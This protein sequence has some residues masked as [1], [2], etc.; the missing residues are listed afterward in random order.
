MATALNYNK[1]NFFELK[2]DI[3][4]Y[5]KQNYPDVFLNLEDNSVGS[6]F[7][8]ILAGTAEANYFNLDRVFQETQLE[9]AQLKKSLF[10]IAKNLGVKLPNKKPSVTLIDIEAIVPA[11][12]D[13]FNETYLPIV[14]AGTQFT[15][16][17]VTFELLGDCDFSTENSIE[18]LPE[19]RT[20]VPIEN[21]Y[22]EIVSYR[23]TKQEVVYNGAT[24]I[25]RR[26][27]TVDESVPFYQIILPEDDIIDIT[28]IVVLQGNITTVPTSDD[29]NNQDL[30]FF[31]VDYL[32]ETEVFLESSPV[33]SENGVRKGEWKK[34]KKKFIKEFNED[35][36]CRITFGGGD[37]NIDVFANSL[38]NAE[39]FSKIETYLY[40]T[41]L[42]QKIPADSTIFIKYRVGGGSNTNLGPNSVTTIVNR[43][44]IVN[45]QKANINE[46]VR[47]TITCNNPIPALGGKD[48][49]SIEEIRNM[50]SYNYGAQNRAV[51]L[52]DYYAIL[53]RMPGKFGV[54]FKFSTSLRNN[55]VIYNIVGLNSD[56]TLN[57]TSTQLLKENISE[58][59]TRHR[60][61]NDYIRVE[62]G[63]I[64][65]LA[66]NINVLVE[67]TTSNDF[68]IIARTIKEIMDFHSVYKQ[69]I[70][71][72]IYIG[73]LYEAINNVPNVININ[74]IICFN[75]TGALY[76]PNKMN[77]VF[78][79][80]TTGQL[81]LSDGILYNTYDGIFEI[82]YNTDIKVTVTKLA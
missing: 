49:L 15:N 25:A 14:K 50:I 12:N 35:G 2:E 16:G 70:G 65:N 31:Q 22:G 76:S 29:F 61:V 43:N 47:N 37:G 67:K 60:M 56:G 46:A 71:Q 69:T 9:N 33:I 40:N 75:K 13:S 51:T 77:A 28:S 11:K 41:S 36:F 27:V 48:E 59:L 80:E 58:F 79:D 24:R 72:N 8:D 19:N 5:I 1:R 20:V 62:D 10:N 53:F 34:V 64:Y 52:E 18:G 44:I 68:E 63:Q 74:S 7:I 82:K 30:Q 73:R 26:Y 55:S 4:N 57:N 42:G 38:E 3:K 81:D 45:G 78:T 17:N 21:N 6:V 54:P 32:A 66:Y 23:I 39:N